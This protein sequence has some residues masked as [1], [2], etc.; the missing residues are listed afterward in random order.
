MTDQNYSN[1]YVQTDM[2][3]IMRLYY[4]NF[5][6]THNIYFAH[7]HIAMSVNLVLANVIYI[8]GGL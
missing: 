2:P 7:V 1:Y 6:R 4:F 3:G 8:L 5:M